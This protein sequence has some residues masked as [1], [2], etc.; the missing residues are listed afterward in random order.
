MRLLLLI[1]QRES[2]GQPGRE[3]KL[4][5]YSGCFCKASRDQT[6]R[7]IRRE[8]K[9]RHGAPAEALMR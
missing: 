6:G 7:E 4:Q 1:G 9:D 3:K 8:Q 5:S 2:P